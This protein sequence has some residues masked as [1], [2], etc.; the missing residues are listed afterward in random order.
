MTMYNTK[1]QIELRKAIVTYG[2]SE[3][4]RIEKVKTLLEDV[5]LPKGYVEDSFKIVKIE[6]EDA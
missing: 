1:I 3:E 2:H 4:E 6:R 5:E